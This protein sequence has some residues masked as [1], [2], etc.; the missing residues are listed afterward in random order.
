MIGATITVT[1]MPA[2]ASRRT[3]SRR[4]RRR[5]GARLHRAGKLAVERGDRDRDLAQVPRS[6]IALQDV[7]VARDQRR[8][9]DD[10]DRMV[11]SRQHLEDRA[12]DAPLALDRLVGIGI[13]PERDRLRRVAGLGELLCQ[14]HRRRWAWRRAWSRN[15]ARR[16]A[17]GSNGSAARSSRCSRARSRGR[18]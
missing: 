5:R 4:L 8:L 10:A 13:C 17:R 2:S 3:A 6:A 12:R 14:Q 11:G 18:D 9:G 15:R 7:D 1:G 16:N